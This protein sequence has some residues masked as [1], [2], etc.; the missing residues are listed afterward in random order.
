MGGG[1]AWIWEP[2]RQRN[3]A[4]SRQR[5]TT[6]SGGLSGGGKFRINRR[7]RTPA[8]WRRRTMKKYLLGA[9]IS[10]LMTSSVLAG[11]IGVSMANSDTFLTVLRKGIEKAAADANQ[12]VR[13]RNRRRR[14]EQA[15][16]ADPE[17][18]RRQGRCH[19]RQRR[20]H[21]GDRAD[22]QARQRCRHS[23]RL[24]QPPA[25]RRRCARP[26]GRLRGVERSR[27]R[28]AR[29][30]G[31]LPPAQG[32]RQDRSQHPDHGGRSRQPGRGDAHQGHPRRHRHAGV[33]RSSRSSTSRPPAGIRSRRRT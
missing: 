32:S 11:D 5:T 28:H 16:L 13:H 33:R 27:F 9:A 15:A 7:H 21:L 12:P 3:G 14:R 19:H 4:G 30:Q 18:H 10:V 31:S 2:T 8:L 6:P 1:A 17:L 22:D 23:D 26:E 29:D 24:C 20:R 25:D